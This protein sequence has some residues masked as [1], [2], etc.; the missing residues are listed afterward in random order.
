MKGLTCSIVWVPRGHM[1]ICWCCWLCHTYTTANTCVRVCGSQVVCD[2]DNAFS[3]GLAVVKA[4]HFSCCCWCI[5]SS[6]KTIHSVQ[7]VSSWRTNRHC[8]PINM[9]DLYPRIDTLYQSIIFRGCAGQ[10][11]AADACTFFTVTATTT[12][13]QKK[14]ITLQHT[15]F[16][17]YTF[18]PIR[19][20]DD[21]FRN[22]Q[23]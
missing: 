1:W 23:G 5:T 4:F 19:K 8:A 3:P 15:Y 13:V 20:K 10:L 6:L 18:P 9:R 12:S 22:A 7:C 2:V 11:S 16:V 14:R 17:H 21:V